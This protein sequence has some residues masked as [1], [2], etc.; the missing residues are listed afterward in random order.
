TITME[1]KGGKIEAETESSVEEEEEEDE[2]DLEEEALKGLAKGLFGKKEKERKE[3]GNIILSITTE[4]T[5][6][7]TDKIN[8]SEFELS[9]NLE[10]E[11][12]K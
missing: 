11:T 1:A 12:K 10:K 3:E 5:E 2:E 6:V 4:M 7:K 8:D 9:P